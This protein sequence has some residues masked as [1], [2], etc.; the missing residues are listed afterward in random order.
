MSTKSEKKKGKGKK[1]STKDTGKKSK[2]QRA[3]EREA[4]KAARK[5]DG[6]FPDILIVTKEKG[7]DEKKHFYGHTEDGE[8]L[9]KN[10]QTVAVYKLRRVSKMVIN[11]KV[12]R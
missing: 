1:S 3:A 7:S 4:K 10:D 2:K 12:A 11:R 5:G 6:S 8:S 9:Y